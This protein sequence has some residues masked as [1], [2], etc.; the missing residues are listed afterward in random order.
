MLKGIC[1]DLE[2]SKKLREL[3]FND[4]ESEFVY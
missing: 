3:G 1:T 4:S 2:T